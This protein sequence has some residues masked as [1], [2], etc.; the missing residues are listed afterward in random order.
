M[1]S[2]PS[3]DP[4]L[5]KLAEGESSFWDSSFWRGFLPILGV[6]AGAF[7]A[8]LLNRAQEKQKIAREVH[9]RWDER[10]LDATSTVLSKI[11]EYNRIAPRNE[12]E[13]L[14][15]KELIA[16][17]TIEADGAETLREIKDVT[18]TYEAYEA[19]A[20]ELAR[21]ELVAPQEVRAITAKMYPV[22]RSVLLGSGEQEVLN[23]TLA[24]E[25]HRDSLE[26]A[27]REHFGLTTEERP[28]EGRS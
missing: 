1:T 5:I 15:R 2:T 13:R 14:S 24:L 4:L 11:D 22:M 23:E 12:R 25:E 26:K 8:Y 7:V 9:T 20:K 17:G 3:P 18:S 21:L 10:I 19:L 27:V 28:T 6:L 16:N